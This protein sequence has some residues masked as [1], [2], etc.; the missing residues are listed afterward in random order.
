M[1][2][3]SASQRPLRCS[4]RQTYKRAS[5]D[6]SGKGNL[7][8]GRTAGRLQTCLSFCLASNDSQCEADLTAALH[9]ADS[10]LH[11]PSCCPNTLQEKQ[12]MLWLWPQSGADARLKSTQKQ[13]V[14]MDIFERAPFPAV[15]SD[16][17]YFIAP[18]N[19]SL[20]LENAL[21]PSHAASLHEGFMGKRKDMVSPC[22]ASLRKL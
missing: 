7:A 22:V 6:C 21:D 14:V 4:C 13:P 18:A 3:L 17:N 12:G 5:F 16:Y 9:F 15:S 8:G 10:S 2:Y 20:L 19:W 1:S 11:S